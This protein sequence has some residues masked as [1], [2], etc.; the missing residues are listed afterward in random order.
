MTPIVKYI[1]DLY[2]EVSPGVLR[3]LYGLD[4]PVEDGGHP[5]AQSSQHVAPRHGLFQTAKN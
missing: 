2:T 3:V 5:L 1:I 4:G